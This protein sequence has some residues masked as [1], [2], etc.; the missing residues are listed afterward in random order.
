M[1]DSDRG[2]HLRN[3][4]NRIGSRTVRVTE[5]STRTDAAE[6]ADSGTTAGGPAP[7]KIIRNK[8][9]RRIAIASQLDEDR[10]LIIP[11]FGERHVTASSLEAYAPELDEWLS[12]HLIAVSDVDE[13][14]KQDLGPIIAIGLTFWLCLIGIPLGYFVWSFQLMDPMLYWMGF[15]ALFGIGLVLAWG[16]GKALLSNVSEALS[17]L[18]ILAIGAGAPGLV[19]VSGFEAPGSSEE[20]NQAVFGR[21]GQWLFIGLASILPASLYFVF[22]RNRLITLKEGFFRDVIRLY[23]SVQTT[24]E[25]EIMY[26]RIFD[27]FHDDTRTG[28]F[29]TSIRL[30]IFLST[31]LITL[32]WM[33]TLPTVGPVGADPHQLFMPLE[34]AVS[35][36]FL[37]AY[38]FS[39]NMLFRRYVRAD[40]GTKAYSHVVTRIF[41]TIVLVWVVTKLP[42][43]AVESLDKALLVLAFCV[44]V[45]PETATVALQDFIRRWLGKG[46]PSL[47]ED[48]PLTKLDGT[49]VYD[50]ARLLE[51]GIENIE[52]LAHHHLVELMV[53][54]R[55]P[56]SRLLD[57]VD[58]AILYLHVRGPAE[59][60]E[61]RADST[62]PLSAMERL[63]QYGI[64]T[65]T[66]LKEAYEAAKNRGEEK[67][68][69][70]LLGP[71][72]AEVKRLQVIL[73]ALQDDEWMVNLRHWRDLN[74][75]SGRVYTL[76]DLKRLQTASSADDNKWSRRDPSE[77]AH[78]RQAAT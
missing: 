55:I 4:A 16:K 43:P 37:G 35:F 15:T 3:I 14:G 63:C 29:L 8:T 72:N 39:L 65:A 36:G 27:E 46:I 22:R 75:D 40:L 32:G 21:F 42:L 60:Q 64:R 2:P 47:R 7:H 70:C 20:F 25:A 28:G 62:K 49:S 23:P 30:P 53:Q 61:T 24:D 78:A 17:F 74:R 44:G 51:E 76:R 41:G 48:H 12:R 33:I 58:Q 67:E 56:T 66:D 19:I 10:Q 5:E 6:T 26:G 71:P 73:D 69:L 52:N 59:V 54:T 9:A 68:L 18:L 1:L 11:P 77:L 34:N 50:L 13:D 38:F 45:V 57:M 31:V